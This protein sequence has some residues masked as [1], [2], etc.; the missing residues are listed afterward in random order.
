MSFSKDGKETE[1][2]L[3]VLGRLVF[4]TTLT[5]YL[6]R[7]EE[8]M[9]ILTIFAFKEI[10]SVAP[11]LNHHEKE[12][13]LEYLINSRSLPYIPEFNLLRIHVN[14]L[15][16][17]N[18]KV[19]KKVTVD[20]MNLNQILIM[21]KKNLFPALED[22]TI[23]TG[24]LIVFENLPKLKKLCL[25]NMTRDLLEIPLLPRDSTNNIEHL[26]LSGYKIEFKG[27][28]PKYLLLVQCY[29]INSGGLSGCETLIM[30]G[31]HW[32]T[33]SYP[34][35]YLHVEGCEIMGNPPETLEEL[36]LVDC[37]VR[38]N[39]SNLKNLKFFKMLNLRAD[40]LVIG[41]N[42]DL[43]ELVANVKDIKTQDLVHIYTTTK[44][45]I[46]GYGELFIPG[47]PNL[48]LMKNLVSLSVHDMN[49]DFLNF[50]KNI[51]KSVEIMEFSK[52]TIMSGYVK[53]TE[54]SM[55]KL[56]FYSCNAPDLY[57]EIDGLQSFVSCG[58]GPLK[59]KDEATLV[60]N[61]FLQGKTMVGL[62][63]LY[64]FELF[65]IGNSTLIQDETDHK[66]PAAAK[67]DQSNT[68]DFQQVFIDIWNTQYWEEVDSEIWKQKINILTYYPY[69]ISRITD[70]FI[71]M[72]LIEKGHD[73]T[74]I[75]FGKQTYTVQEIYDLYKNY[76]SSGTT[77]NLD[78]GLSDMFP[79]IK[80]RLTKNE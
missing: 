42:L 18:Y 30:S 78:Q 72:T 55:K 50:L 20:E 10:N 53:K 62:M 21:I 15:T 80:I 43:Y 49:I 13:L 75:T 70:V 71:L 34:S 45:S 48:V 63:T 41:P 64:Q 32:N 37:K 57:I 60:T 52:C 4:R 8:K 74:K 14:L 35:K 69:N 16:D 44:L 11:L 33:P 3:E 65:C 29:V 61:R 19:L 56:F 17:I 38:Y 23:Y 67:K 1:G 28:L 27:K 66:K 40:A 51:P 54:V 79:I 36:H 24:G 9:D 46:R 31:V 5:D 39:L 7:I 26:E 22:L 12:E 68:F 2:M 47:T 73:A 77:G 59:K 58:N 25:Y 76:E 6:K